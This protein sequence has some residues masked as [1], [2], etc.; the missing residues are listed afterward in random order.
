M[1]PSTRATFTVRPARFSFWNFGRNFRPAQVGVSLGD[2][3]TWSDSPSTGQSKPRGFP[4]P[5]PIPVRVRRPVRGAAAPVSRAVRR[6]CYYWPS[7]RARSCQYTSAW[8][9]AGKNSFNPLG[10]MSNWR[11]WPSLTVRLT[12]GRAKKKQY[13]C[14]R[15]HRPRRA[16]III[17]LN[18]IYA[19]VVARTVLICIRRTSTTRAFSPP[20][21][22]HAISFFDHMVSFSGPRRT[23]K[24]R[25]RVLAV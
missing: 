22:R 20:P 25:V 8:I 11:N 18:R 12:T 7:L 1:P 16:R 2:G 9:P 21:P 10:G 4:L 23:R 19:A 17:V 15:S 24:N 5:S 13:N 6:P 14:F 3:H